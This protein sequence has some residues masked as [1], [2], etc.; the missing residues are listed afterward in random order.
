MMCRKAC[1]VVFGIL[2]WEGLRIAVGASACR[3]KG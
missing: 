2:M 3:G 1:H